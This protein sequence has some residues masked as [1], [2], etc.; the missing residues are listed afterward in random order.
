VIARN[1]CSLSINERARSP[2]HPQR[3]IGDHFFSSIAGHLVGA[4]DLGGK[5]GARMGRDPAGHLGRELPG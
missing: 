5:E 3:F 4:M 2:K 1:T